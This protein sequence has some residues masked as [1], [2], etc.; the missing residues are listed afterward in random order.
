[1]TTTG[2]TPLTDA[3]TIVD[4]ERRFVRDERAAFDRFRT[5]LSDIEPTAVEATDASAG[6]GAAAATVVSARSDPSPGRPLRAV[7]EAYRE[8]VM[9][10]PHYET[11]YG[12][13][14]RANLTTE[15]STEVASQVTD[16]TRLTPPLHR[17]LVVGSESASEDRAQFQ[18]SLERERDSLREVQP[19]LVEVR[20]RVA[21][22]EQSINRAP[23]ETLSRL[24]GR[25]AALEATCGDLANERQRLVHGRSGVSLS[26]VTGTSLMSFLYGDCKRRCP[27]LSAIA[28]CLDRIRDARERCLR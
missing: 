21:G 5:R 6:V 1:M 14:L 11:E 28:G 26:G 25:L 24:D 18:R 22:I 9:A 10:V 16:G 27:A 4:R 20:R 13:T 12:D 2:D 17:A 23:T 8:T 7:Q 15:F 3:L 19:E